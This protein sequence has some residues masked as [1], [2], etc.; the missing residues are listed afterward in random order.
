[1]GIL[2]LSFEGGYIER[3]IAK[4]WEQRIFQLFIIRKY[5]ITIYCN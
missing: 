1:M 3:W 4:D 5:H 2:Q